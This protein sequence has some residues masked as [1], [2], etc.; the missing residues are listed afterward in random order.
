[1][2]M[3][4]WIKN[5][6][7]S[8]VAVATLAG[9]LYI[10]GH[11]LNGK[12]FTS[13]CQEDPTS[14]LEMNQVIDDVEYLTSIELCNEQKTLRETIKEKIKDSSYKSV[15][16]TDFQCV[17][18]SVIDQE[19][20]KELF[21]FVSGKQLEED[22]DSQYRIY[23]DFLIARSGA[24]ENAEYKITADA[25]IARIDKDGKLVKVCYKEGLIDLEIGMKD[26][27]AYGFIKGRKQIDTD[28]LFSSKVGLKAAV[29][30]LKITPTVDLEKFTAVDADQHNAYT[31]LGL[32][33]KTNKIYYN[34]ENNTQDPHSGFVYI[35]FL[36]EDKDGNYSFYDNKLSNLSGLEN[37]KKNF[38]S[39]LEQA[40]VLTSGVYN[41]EASQVPSQFMK[42][43]AP[44]KSIFDG[45]AD[46]WDLSNDRIQDVFNE[47]VHSELKKEELS[48]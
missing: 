32:T 45:I 28:K 3:R 13:A 30:N 2:P 41:V 47:F 38:D 35:D 48:K 5:G 21:E 22:K 23:T 6:V 39:I 14:V 17:K 29:D 10:G 26:C 25:Y 36:V 15:Y 42:T 43:K 16:E 34:M 9:S 40:I 11:H 18:D 24:H 8:L 12:L 1:M 44:A 4:K 7:L 33:D 19:Y 46:G 37:A 27:L 20:Q 31:L